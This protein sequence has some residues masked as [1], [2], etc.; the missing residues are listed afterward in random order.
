MVAGDVVGGDRQMSV[1]M[2]K[3]HFN[4][5]IY[6]FSGFPL[7]SSVGICMGYHFTQ[8]KKHL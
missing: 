3:N 2:L 4:Q 8:E 7:L 5:D 6:K 1:R